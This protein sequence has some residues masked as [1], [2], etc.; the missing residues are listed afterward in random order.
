MKAGLFFEADIGTCSDSWA[1]RN[2]CFMETT[3]Q[4][5]F[6]LP[7]L[8]EG[9]LLNPPGQAVPIHGVRTALPCGPRA[10]AV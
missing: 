6:P 3:P 5:S 10:G 1:D 4:F 2:P 9:F 7:F 8:K